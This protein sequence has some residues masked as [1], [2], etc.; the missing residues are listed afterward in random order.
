[1]HAQ[2]CNVNNIWSENR[3]VALGIDWKKG[4]YH[5]ETHNML[6]LGTG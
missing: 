4:Q 3:M 6:E 1:M 2:I 5:Q